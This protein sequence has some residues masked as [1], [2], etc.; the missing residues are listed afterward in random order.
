MRVWM[1]FSVMPAVLV[2]KVLVCWLQVH[3][4][5]IVMVWFNSCAAGWRMWMWALV[6]SGWFVCVVDCVD[7]QAVQ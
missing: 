3:S 2:G 5:L 6:C 4:N 1:W 7:R